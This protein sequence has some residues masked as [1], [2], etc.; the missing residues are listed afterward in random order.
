[1]A[2][3]VLGL[4]T[5]HGS[6]VSLTPEWWQEHGKLDRERTDY[7]EL[8]ATADPER[9][10][11]ELTMETMQRKYEAAQRAVGEVSAS[12]L[13]SNPD[14]VV[15]VGD[16]Q[17]EMFPRANMPALAIY[18]GAGVDDIPRDLTNVP[19][20]RKAAMWAK[21][22]EQRETYP[23]ADDLGTGLVEQMMVA[24]FDVTQMSEQPEGRSLGHAF[25]FVRLR[26]MGE[27]IIPILPIMLNT[28]YPPNQPRAARCYEFGKALGRAIRE[29]EDP[30]R[31]AI[32]ASGGLSHFAVDEALDR[33]V[34]EALAARDADALRSL[35]E[36]KLQSGSS[37]IK[38]WIVTAA[39]VGDLDFELID[40]LPGYRSPAGTGCGLGFVRWV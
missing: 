7:D 28:Y 17:G 37:E 38:N 27:D 32:V 15:I 24:G 23:V 16:D 40:Y 39:A 10:E 29:W 22:A 6:Q 19:E 34:L 4:G 9:I 21:H 20:S 1:M 3:I 8:L 35:P 18:R 31:V 25:T 36:R 13:K 30:R 11:P 33:G 14:V 5:S 2:E 26:L 12:L